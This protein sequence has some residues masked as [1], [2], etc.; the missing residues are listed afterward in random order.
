MSRF[1]IEIF[2]SPM[3]RNFL[4]EPFCAVFQKISGSEKVY[5]EEGGGKYQDFPSKNFCFTVPR[6]FVRE[7]FR[8]SL[9]WG[10]EKFCASEGYVT[11]ICRIFF[12]SQLRKIL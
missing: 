1:S 6:N 2:L 3:P 4:A 8:V 7:P 9:N 11:I 5:G 10:I 12:D